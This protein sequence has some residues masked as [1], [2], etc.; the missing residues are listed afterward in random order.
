VTIAGVISGA[1]IMGYAIAALFFAK[2]WRRTRD[3]LFLAFAAAFVLLAVGPLLMIVLE[4]PREEQSPFF[5]L[6]LAAFGI[7]IAAIVAKS[8]GGGARP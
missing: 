4:V 8:R 6:R 5:L 2:F 3:G 1:I 7:L